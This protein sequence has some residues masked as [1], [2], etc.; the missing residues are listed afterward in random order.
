[1]NSNKCNLC[2]GTKK[3][4]F[5]SMKTT[6]PCPVTIETKRDMESKECVSESQPPDKI[7][8]PSKRGRKKKII[9]E[10]VDAG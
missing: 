2:G 3:Y 1:M 8:F 9:L 10:S 5:G 4:S 6:C 7:T